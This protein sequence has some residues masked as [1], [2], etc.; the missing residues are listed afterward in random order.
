MADRLTKLRDAFREAKGDP[1]MLTKSPEILESLKI[2]AKDLDM[3][4]DWIQ[5]LKVND[6]S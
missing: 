1:R 4:D 5:K 2:L 6:E 3:N